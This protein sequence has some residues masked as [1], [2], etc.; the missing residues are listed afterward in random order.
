LPDL[1]RLRGVSTSLGRRSRRRTATVAVATRLTDA[2]EDRFV[3]QGV[4]DRRD[5]VGDHARH[6]VGQRFGV[7]DDLVLA[8]S[9]HRDLPCP[10]GTGFD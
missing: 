10:V 8:G 1:A 6:I 7:E 4:N 3:L 9:G 5:R 2:E